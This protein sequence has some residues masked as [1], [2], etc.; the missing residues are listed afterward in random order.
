MRP[1]FSTFGL[2]L[3]LNLKHICKD[4]GCF[5]DVGIHIDTLDSGDKDYQVTFKVCSLL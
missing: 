2:K 4:L 1:Q 5:S 3:N